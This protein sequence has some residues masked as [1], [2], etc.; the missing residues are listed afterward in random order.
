MIASIPLFDGDF[1]LRVVFDIVFFFPLVEGFD[2]FFDSGVVGGARHAFMDCDV[3]GCADGGEA[4]GAGKECAGRGGA[5]Y[6]GAVGGGAVLE[7]GG[8]GLDVCRGGGFENFFEG[9]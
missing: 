7:I 3:A 2:I 4:G 6:G 5:V 1:A 8:V 9:G